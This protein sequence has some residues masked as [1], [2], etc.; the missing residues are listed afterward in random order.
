MTFQKILI[1]LQNS[2]PKCFSRPLEMCFGAPR[3]KS[4]WFSASGAKHSPPFPECLVALRAETSGS[5]GECD[6]YNIS[7]NF[8]F[9]SKFAS[10]MRP[11]AFRNVFLHA[12]A[13]KQ[14]IS[15]S[16]AKHSPPFLHLLVALRAKIR[17]RHPKD[18]KIWHFRFFS[19][20]SDFE[21]SPG[22]RCIVFSCFCAPLRKSKWS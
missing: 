16:G 5:N 20:F 14:M 2:H 12:A 21:L 15:G 13:Q 7:G 4:K 22:L 3:R 11:E 17:G 19:N 9:S 18:D 8:S 10:K 6:K 1:F